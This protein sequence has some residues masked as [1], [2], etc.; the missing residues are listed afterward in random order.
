MT[1]YMQAETLNS[2]APLPSDQTVDNTQWGRIAPK[3]N[4]KKGFFGARRILA[5]AVMGATVAAFSGCAV[6]PGMDFPEKSPITPD[7]P[8]RYPQVTPITQEVVIQQD[9]ERQKADDAERQLA[10]AQLVGKA[11]PYRIGAADVLSVIVWEHPELVLPNVTYD[12]GATKGATN[13]PYVGTT[14]SVGYDVS[15]DGYIQFPYVGL[16]K[17]AGETEVQ[18]QRT[19]TRGLLPY[20]TKPQLTVRVIGYN[21]Q[22]VFVDGAVTT[23]GAL[24]IT[25]IPMTLGLALNSV[26]GVTALGDRSRVY[27]DR[28]GKTYRINLTQLSRIGVTPSQIPLRDNDTIHV[29]PLSSNQVAV[30]GEVL[31]A[32]SVSLRTNGQLTLSEALGDVGSVNPASAKPQSIYVLRAQ[33]DPKLPPKIFRLDAKSAAAMTLAQQFPLQGKDVVYVDAGAL[34]RWSR[35]ITLVTGSASIANTGSDIATR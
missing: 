15:D 1:T 14:P 7:D 18:I 5:M 21:S 25:S 3:G 27:L 4:I 11:P 29:E 28:D 30:V 6:I 34:V 20:I 8:D 16:V 2:D 26:G 19:L 9:Q 23:P 24:P 17:V 32:N 22:H 13:I 35:L 31:R 10:F 33:K 12:I